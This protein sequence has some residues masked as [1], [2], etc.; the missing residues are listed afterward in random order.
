MTDSNDENDKEKSGYI[1][2]KNKSK[3]NKPQE[4]KV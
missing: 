4:N 2:S 3:L 1:T